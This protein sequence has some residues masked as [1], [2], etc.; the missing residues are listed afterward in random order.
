VENYY[1]AFKNWL[2]PSRKHPRKSYQ[3]DEEGYNNDKDNKVFPLEKL[4]LTLAELGVSY[5]YWS[6]L[7]CQYLLEPNQHT[8]SIAHTI[9]EGDFGILEDKFLCCLVFYWQV[10]VATWKNENMY[11]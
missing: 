9:V 5:E 2:K 1:K 10:V 7:V 6:H 8:P 3:G 4:L 11:V